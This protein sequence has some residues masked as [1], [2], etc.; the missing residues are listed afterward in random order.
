M[1]TKVIGSYVVGYENGD[2]VIY[3]DGEVIYEN[4]RILSVGKRTETQT[5]AL[6]DATGHIVS[7]GF[8]DL[9]ALVDFDHGILDVVV[10][11]QGST[12]FRM[13]P[14]RFRTEERLTRKE[15]QLRTRLSYAQ[16]IRNGITTGMPIAGDGL[17]A[18]AETYEEMADNAAIA[19]EMGIRMYLGP[20]YRTYPSGSQRNAEDPRG[21]WSFAEA[22]RFL[23]DFGSGEGLVQTFLSPCQLLNLSEE[24]LKETFQIAG[25]ENIPVRLHVGESLQELEYLKEKYGMTPV[26]YLNS[27]GALRQGTI[28][29]HVL[30]TRPSNPLDQY[31]EKPEDELHIL[32]ESGAVVMHAPIAESHG[33][34]ALY[35]LSRYLG[36]GIHMAFGTDTHP[37]DMIQ[38]MNFAWNLT[39]IF[40]SGSIIPRR[41]SWSYR[42]TEADIYRMATLGGAYALGRED[43]GRLCPG[44][45]A[46]IITVDLRGI[47]TVPV[48]DPIRTLIMNTTGENVKNVVID[49][50]TVMR[51]GTIPSLDWENLRKEAQNGFDAFRESYSWFD[52]RRRTGDV[53]FPAG[54]EIR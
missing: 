3:R 2:H 35:S 52:V 23:E 49:G 25:Q 6:I 51:E 50:R 9:D 7:P 36:A 47:R 43:I 29:P 5:D 13:D 27:I 28:L 40:D 44:A 17:R 11:K 16:L 4:D 31:P 10:P 46:D 33:G 22:M 21:A 12:S 48:E 1:K 8:I 14:N 54:Y 41:A 24:V 53:L 38:N 39:R 45:K 15:R 42:A 30:Y 18:W 32:A 34:T 37:A 19:E 26:E 20:S